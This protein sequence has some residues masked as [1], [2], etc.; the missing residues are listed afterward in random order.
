MEE[1]GATDPDNELET[2][3]ILLAASQHDIVKLRTLLRIGSASVQDPETGFTPLHAAIAACQSSSSSQNGVQVNGQKIHGDAEKFLDEEQVAEEGDMEAAVKTVKLLLENGAIWNDVNKNNETPGCLA[4]RLGL[5]EL[6]SVMVDAGVRVEILLNRLDE[7][8]P[9]CDGADED[10]GEVE[11]AHE[12]ENVAAEDPQDVGARATPHTDLRTDVGE[13]IEANNSEDF[14]R[15][16][17]TFRDGRIL[18][19][20]RN[21]V[22]MAWEFDIM[23]CT[24]D[25]LSPANGLRILNIGHGMGIIDDLFQAKSPSAHHIIEA[26][27]SVLE[28]MKRKG[29]FDRPAVTVHEGRWQNVIPKIMEQEQM[30]DVIYFDTFAEDYKALQGFFSDFVLGLLE[31]GGKWGFFNGLGADR[32]ICYDVYT[33]VVEMDLFEA[34]FDTHWETLHVP[35]LEEN[36]EW[37]DV[38]RRYWTLNE[39]KLPVCYFAG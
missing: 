39:Y 28:Q 15:S 16:G 5:K 24:A 14:L 33:K 31:D 6:Y 29:W 30:F 3:Q 11:K 38:R 7:Y 23:K 21:A 8:E 27:P 32:Q 25:L 18:D 4:L 20:S 37:K 10:D 35:N 9:L 17:L 22:M 2:Q 26:H 19:E 13:S 12:A 36:D 34:G 1:Q